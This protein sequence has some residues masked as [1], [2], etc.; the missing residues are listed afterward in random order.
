MTTTLTKAEAQARFRTLTQQYGVQ[1]GPE[2]PAAAHE[3]L[4]EINAVLTRRRP[5]EALGLPRLRSLGGSAESQRDVAERQR[6]RDAGCYEPPR[7][8]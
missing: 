8:R 3:A 5:P 7:R 1:W 2:V 6:L 4:R